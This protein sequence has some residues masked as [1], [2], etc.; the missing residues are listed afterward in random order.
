MYIGCDNSISLESCELKLRS[1]TLQKISGRY[2]QTTEKQMESLLQPI[3]LDNSP[4]ELVWYWK[5][6]WVQSETN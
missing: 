2:L 4:S 6:G 1:N 3:V 5:P